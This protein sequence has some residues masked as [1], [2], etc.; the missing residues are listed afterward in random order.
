MDRS[1]QWSQSPEDVGAGGGEPQARG[2]E[3]AR[4]SGSVEAGVESGP[5]T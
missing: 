5:G 1:A 3:K 4:T 2:R